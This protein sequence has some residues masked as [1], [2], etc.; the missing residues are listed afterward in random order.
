MKHVHSWERGQIAHSNAGEP[1]ALPGGGRYLKGIAADRGR[2]RMNI[3]VFIV[4]LLRR[5]NALFAHTEIFPS[6]NV[7]NRRDTCSNTELSNRCV[8]DDQEE[9]QT[10]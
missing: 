9:E 7:Q 2:L 8:A 1:P 5:H 4:P 3:V 6:C 10:L